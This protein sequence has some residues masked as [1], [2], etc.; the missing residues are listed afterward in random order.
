L[1]SNRITGPNAVVCGLA[2][3]SSSICA[4]EIARAS[5]VTDNP[6]G[7]NQTFNDDFD[8]SSLDPNKWANRLP[9]PRNSAINT[10]DAVS[11]DNGLLTIKTYTVDGV[12]YTGMIGSQDKFEQ[13]YGYYE[14]RMKFHTKAGQWSAF[15]LTAQDFDGKVGNPA[16]YGTEIDVVEHRALNSNNGE[17]RKRYVSAV[18]WD[19]Y[20]DDAKQLAITHPGQPD[21]GNDTWHTFGLSWSPAGYDFYYDDKFMWGVTQAVS[22]RDEYMIISSE[23]KQG[24][25]AGDITAGG[26]GSLASTITN[27][28]VDYVHVYEALPEPTALGLIATLAPFALS[29]KRRNQN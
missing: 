6:T 18:H 3:L 10:P 13:T 29:R 4:G 21:F 7:W 23:V 19:G 22:A 28:Q 25:W 2:L 1:D 9:G 12:H 15:W 16:L 26:Y 5:I 20:G 14:A 27:V 8:G 24:G 11:V 17:I